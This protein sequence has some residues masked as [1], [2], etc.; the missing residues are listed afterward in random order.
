[1]EGESVTL[2]AFEGIL[3][4]QPDQDEIS[5]KRQVNTKMQKTT[6]EQSP[7]HLW[8]NIAD[9][10]QTYEKIINEVHGIG[11]YRTEF[12]FMKNSRAFP[13]ENE[14]YKAY[15]A[16]FNK[17]KK[18]PITIR[19][20]DIGGD[21]N[22][23]YFSFGPQLNPYLG[24]R[25]HR[26]YRYHPE[27]FRDQARA[28]LRAAVSIKHLR[29]LYPM[30]ESVD[31]LLFVKGLLQ[32][33][34]ESL[35]E[36]RLPHLRTFQQGVLIEVPSAAWNFKELLKYV[37]FASIG[38]NDLLQYFFALDR[39][40]ANVYRFYQPENPAALRMLKSLIAT[41]KNVHKPLNICGE[42]A[43]DVR[44]LPLL[45]GLGFENLSIDSH[46]VQDVR[47]YLSGLDL[48][49]CK[50]LVQ[51]CL[52]ASNTAETRALIDKFHSHSKNSTQSYRGD[53][54]SIDP[55]CNMVVHTEGNTLLV[56]DGKRTNYFCSV[57][58]R[59]RYLQKKTLGFYD[60]C[61]YF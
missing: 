33:A 50:D 31:E 8:V 43:S 15:S 27:I 54:E 6:L 2:D 23:P 38:T 20:L 12:L 52:R 46:T 24:L 39:N 7:V 18:I 29:I 55:I 51:K 34:L 1:M 25:A 60:K 17:C 41:A 13:T 49:S 19:T 4:I 28:I 57:A 3:Y 58:C 11:L 9:P 44:F 30:I 47:K 40:N 5:T 59:D 21:K 26:V 36:E 37:D 53:D 32:E 16:L 35:R 61:P 10:Q 14:Q 22:L 45:I 56:K 42:I 48:T